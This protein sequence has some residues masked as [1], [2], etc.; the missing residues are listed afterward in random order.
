MWHVLFTYSL[1]DG[2]WGCT[3]F[4]AV[5]S[6][7]SVNIYIEKFTGLMPYPKVSKLRQAGRLCYPE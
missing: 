2:D 4:G 7:L 1:I 6:R 3:Q 5:T